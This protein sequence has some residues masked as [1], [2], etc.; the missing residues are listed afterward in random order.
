[1]RSPG[2]G[3]LGRWIPSPAGGN[4][5]VNELREV[6]AGNGDGTGEMAGP[7][8]ALHGGR[9]RLPD[10]SCGVSIPR[11]M[12]LCVTPHPRTLGSRTL[13]PAHRIG[14]CWSLDPLDYSNACRMIRTT[15]LMTSRKVQGARAASD[16]SQP[17]YD[18]SQ[19][20][21]SFHLS[22]SSMPSLVPENSLGRY[23]DVPADLQL[24]GAECR[25]G[26]SPGRL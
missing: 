2:R 6:T 25:K 16:E 1:M 15:V 7:E 3:S 18:I 11:P 24:P 8:R 13:G 22:P 9:P 21:V 20:S 17:P 4:E 5:S 12:V 23:W 19:G 10:T 14:V 26:F